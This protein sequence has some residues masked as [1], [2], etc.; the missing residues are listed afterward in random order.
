MSEREKGSSD[1]GVKAEQLACEWLTE[2]GL[3]VV[4]KNWRCRNLELDIIH[5]PY[6]FPVLQIQ[7]SH[8]DQNRIHLFYNL[9]DKF[10]V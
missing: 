2:Q 4:A 7:D 10:P 6:N 9:K 8:Q 5:L 1:K 3:R